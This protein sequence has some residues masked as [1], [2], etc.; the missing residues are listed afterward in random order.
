MRDPVD[1]TLINLFRREILLIID[2]KFMDDIIKYFLYAVF[3][4]MSFNTQ[5]LVADVFFWL[6]PCMALVERGA[7]LFKKKE[8]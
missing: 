3:F 5:N 8:T 7:L 6:F 4:L 2:Q 1:L